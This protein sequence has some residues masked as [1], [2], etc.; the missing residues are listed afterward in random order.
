MSSVLET[1]TRHKA[2]II[3]ERSLAASS[4]QSAAQAGN[5]APIAEAGRFDFP[6]WAPGKAYAKN[7]LFSYNGMVGFARQ[8]VTAQAHQPPFS[9]GMEAIYG[10]RPR[11]DKFGIYPY[12]YNMASDVGM[13]VREGTDVY[14]CIQ[15]YPVMTYPPSQVPAHFTKEGQ[16]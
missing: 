12:A 8:A 2:R 4:I 9:P 13:R 11:P 15:A 7:E 16:S 3:K 5:V 10:V 14:L 6:S 1:L